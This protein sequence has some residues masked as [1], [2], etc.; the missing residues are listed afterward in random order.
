MKEIPVSGAVAQLG[1]VEV[2]QLETDEGPRKIFGYVV[3]AE[4]GVEI[5]SREN[6]SFRVTEVYDWCERELS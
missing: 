1:N 5:L 2:L 3:E 4:G 6:A